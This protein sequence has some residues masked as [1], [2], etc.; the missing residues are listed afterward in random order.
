M[1]K[2]TQI[3]IDDSGRVHVSYPCDTCS[4]W[5]HTEDHCGDTLPDGTDE[6]MC[7]DCYGKEVRKVLQREAVKATTSR[8]EWAM[9]ADPQVREVQDDTGRVDPNIPELSEEMCTTF[10]EESGFKVEKVEGFD[11]NEMYI[12]DWLIFIVDFDQG[13]YCGEY[14][15]AIHKTM[16][17]PGL[18]A[19]VPDCSSPEPD[20]GITR[21][22][23]GTCA[24]ALDC[25]ES[26]RHTSDD[27]Y[28]LVDEGYIRSDN[29][30]LIFQAQ[31][32]IIDGVEITDPTMSPCGRFPVKQCE[33]DEPERETR[34]GGRSVICTAC[35]RDA[36]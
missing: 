14:R 8:L 16:V 25:I 22:G 13:T 21:Y 6:Y 2:P 28:T 1:S 20:E 3:Y 23:P 34:D 15:I 36:S 27:V 31:D 10:L 26:L 9:A 33:C 11:L 5:V 35:G 4:E 30:H 19:E 7:P 32:V 24:T 17:N 18:G 12:H 29:A